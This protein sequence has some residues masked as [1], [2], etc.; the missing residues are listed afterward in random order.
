M[1]FSNS[2][3]NMIKEERSAS[4]VK[5]LSI[6]DFRFKPETNPSEIYKIDPPDTISFSLDIKY[7][8]NISAGSNTY[9]SYKYV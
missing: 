4:D 1:A 9:I 8:I 7:I 6:V 2:A 5:S 3:A